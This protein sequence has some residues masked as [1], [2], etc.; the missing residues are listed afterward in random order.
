MKRYNAKCK[1][2]RMTKECCEVLGITQS[3]NADAKQ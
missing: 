3:S 2:V 1:Y